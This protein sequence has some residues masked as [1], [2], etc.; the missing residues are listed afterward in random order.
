M[1]KQTITFEL[2]FIYEG[3]VGWMYTTTTGPTFE[4]CKEKA[5]KHFQKQ[6]TEL[7]W[8]RKTIIVEVRKQRHG[9]DVP[10]R[11]VIPDTSLSSVRKSSTGTVR[12]RSKAVGAKGKNQPARKRKGNPTKRKKD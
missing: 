12:S 5:E 10:Q 8:K 3:N 4:K 9:T 11:R 1:N 7:G 6:L 2:E